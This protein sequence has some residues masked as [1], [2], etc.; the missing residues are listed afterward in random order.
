M[1]IVVF[2]EKTVLSSIYKI[3]HKYI[4]Y[5]CYISCVQHMSI[6]IYA[7]EICYSCRKYNFG[8][9]RLDIVILQ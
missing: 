6:L 1:N 7:T 2:L 4:A 8:R 5:K 9:L 3:K